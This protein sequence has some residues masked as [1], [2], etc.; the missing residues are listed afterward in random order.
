MS[1]EEGAV[2]LD[3]RARAAMIRRLTLATV[4][5]LFF[6]AGPFL[7]G[8]GEAAAA[9]GGGMGRLSAGRAGFVL[10][11]AL[12][13]LGLGVLAAELAKPHSVG[14]PAVFTAAF[15]TVW[16]VMLMRSEGGFAFFVYLVMT[17]PAYLLGAAWQ[18]RVIALRASLARDDP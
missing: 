7:F 10:V 8:L 9:L 12:V 5:P 15:V 2:A 14:P 17:A 6:L 13:P 3:A 18:T 4:V 16:G 11:M 1:T